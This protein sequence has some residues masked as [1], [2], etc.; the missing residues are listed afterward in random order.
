MRCLLLDMYSSK[1]IEELDYRPGEN[2]LQTLPFFDREY[3]VATHN[4]FDF[5]KWRFFQS[6]DFRGGMR[7]RVFGRNLP[8]RLPK[9]PLFKNL[10][11]TYLSQGMHAIN[12]ASIANIQG[13]V[14]HTKFLQDFPMMIQE[15]AIREQH[16]D[17]GIMYK[18]FNYK[19]K[20]DGLVSFHY[21]GSSRFSDS[22][23]LVQMDIMKTSAALESFN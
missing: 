18:I 16:F 19:M 8:Y 12:G 20:K 13:V 6:T 9:I 22:Q 15:E 10:P 7:E 23:N 21:E 4:F 11:K 17:K 5:S 3:I 2:P 1:P 14:F